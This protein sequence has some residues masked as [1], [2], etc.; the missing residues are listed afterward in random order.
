MK[1]LRILLF[2]MTLSG[3]A[4]AQVREPQQLAAL[5]VKAFASGDYKGFEKVL[6]D[7]ADLEDMECRYASIDNIRLIHIGAVKLFEDIYFNLWRSGLPPAELKLA[8]MKVLSREQMTL[9]IHVVLR[10]HHG[11]LMVPYLSTAN[12]LKIVNA[13]ELESRPAAKLKEHF[14]AEVQNELKKTITDELQFSCRSCKRIVAPA[15]NGVNILSNDSIVASLYGES[16][17]REVVV[18]KYFRN[19]TLKDSS[20][21]VFADDKGFIS[22]MTRWP[23]QYAN[24]THI[25]D[26]TATLVKTASFW[27][28]GKIMFTRHHLHRDTVLLKAFHNNALLAEESK[29]VNEKSIVS[30]QYDH[31]GK[32]KSY[33]QFFNRPLALALP[34]LETFPDFDRVYARY[35]NGVNR[36]DPVWFHRQP[37]GWYVELKSDGKQYLLWSFEKQAFEELPAVFNQPARTRPM[38]HQPS[39][40]LE[41]KSRE[42]LFSGYAHAASES[43]IMLERARATLTVQQL[44]MLQVSYFEWCKALLLSGNAGNK[45][46]TGLLDQFAE[47]TTTLAKNGTERERASSFHYSA[48]LDLLLLALAPERKEL[49]SPVPDTKPGRVNESTIK[50]FFHDCEQNAVFIT[51]REASFSY[52]Q[53][54]NFFREDIIVIGISELN[55]PWY[56]QYVERKLK[57]KSGTIFT[58]T[59]ALYNYDSINATVDYSA[60][61]KDAA[62]LLKS[63]SDA[64][65]KISVP[66]KLHLKNESSTTPVELNLSPGS[67]GL[68]GVE[69]LHYLATAGKRNHVYGSFLRVFCKG[70]IT[71]GLAGTKIDLRKP[72]QNSI[73]FTTTFKSGLN[74]PLLSQLPSFTLADLLR[75]TSVYIYQNKNASGKEAYLRFTQLYT[76]DLTGQLYE[77]ALAMV[78]HG[79]ATD[80]KAPAMKLLEKCVIYPRDYCAQAEFYEPD[81]VMKHN[82]EMRSFLKEKGFVDVAEKYFPER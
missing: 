51:D 20:V 62:E 19:K 59:P 32:L 80:N 26:T 42:V 16:V 10:D 7:T 67:F 43:I 8:E 68:G 18:K 2:F 9:F 81:D 40:P 54:K 25:T 5:L 53:R 70:E 23:Q 36:R 71:Y 13:I 44:A 35:H 37:R 28:D 1:F 57:V 21:F 65:V 34:E 47:L 22:A 45:E 73:V 14:N 69:L 12:G 82:F 17:T 77:T 60:Q 52:Y 4:H 61:P 29:R 3:G 74:S 41:N 33:K 56:R 46:I 11:L 58:L 79:L 6:L 31:L 24:E 76:R 15:D 75:R 48:S 66:Y 72:A 55:E 64:S 49:L 78:K 38:H 63:L 39:N 50:T 30:R 27:P